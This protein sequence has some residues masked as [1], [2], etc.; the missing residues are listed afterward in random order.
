MEASRTTFISSWKEELQMLHP[1]AALPPGSEAHGALSGHLFSKD[2][3]TVFGNYAF[4]LVY[5]WHVM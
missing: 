2:D 1:M 3:T 4:F 5:D